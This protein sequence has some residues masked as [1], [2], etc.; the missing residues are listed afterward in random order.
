M[1]W[2]SVSATL[3]AILMLISILMDNRPLRQTR[4]VI[5]WRQMITKPR[6]LWALWK[7]RQLMKGH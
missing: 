4:I 5:D 3:L 6:L 2:L 7:M 1:W